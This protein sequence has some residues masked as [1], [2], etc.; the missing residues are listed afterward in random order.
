MHSHTQALRAGEEVLISYGCIQK[1]NAELMRDYGFTLTANINDRWRGG[2]Q[3]W[4]R[5]RRRR[6]GMLPSAL[7]NVPCEHAMERARPSS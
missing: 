1:S 4:T 3:R 2:G 5:E 7:L 6:G